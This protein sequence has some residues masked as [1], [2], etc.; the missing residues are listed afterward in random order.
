MVLMLL[1]GGFLVCR[2]VVNTRHTTVQDRSADHSTAGK[3]AAKAMYQHS[4]L[5]TPQGI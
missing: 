1:R 4:G 5:R 3:W 2:S